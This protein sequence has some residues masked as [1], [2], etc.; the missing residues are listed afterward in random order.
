MAWEYNI[1]QFATAERWSEE[2]RIAEVKRL[3]DYANKLGA[4]G[5]EMV[6]FQPVPTHPVGHAFLVIFKRPRA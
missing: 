1:K 6:A 5:W 2:A 4:D 3:D